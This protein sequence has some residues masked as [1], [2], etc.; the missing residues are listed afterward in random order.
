MPSLY[1]F[2]DQTD[3]SKILNRLRRLDASV[4]RTRGGVLQSTGSGMTTAPDGLFGPNGQ[5]LLASADISKVGSLSPTFNNTGFGI[6]ATDVGMVIY[7]DG[8]NAGS[9]I[10]V[11]HRADGTRLAIPPGQITVTGLTAGTT[12]YALPFWSSYNQC[13]IGWVQGTVGAPQILFTSIIDLTNAWQQNQANREPL[14]S[15]YLTFATNT[16]S[17]SYNPP[18]TAPGGG[19]LH[20]VM[21]GTEIE[22]VDGEDYETKHYHEG[23]WWYIRDSQRHWLNCTINHRLYDAE[24]FPKQAQDFEIGDVIVHRTGNFE[25]VE[26]AQFDRACTKVEVLMPRVHLFWANGFLSHNIKM[27]PQ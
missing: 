9:Q 24:G 1:G 15:T 6:S 2:A 21:L 27:N 13:T 4:P 20:C 5:V 19:T 26:S 17:A 14:T 23:V 7:W 22:T 16:S 12:Y 10:I 8:V 3:T 18:V 25:V 11:L